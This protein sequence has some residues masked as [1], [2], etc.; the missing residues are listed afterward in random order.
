MTD[1]WFD[2]D[3]C[4]IATSGYDTYERIFKGWAV[5]YK[6]ERRH[7]HFPTLKGYVKRHHEDVYMTARAYAR[8]MGEI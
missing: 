8:V 7:G 6:A 5:E 1:N 4:I 2:I 3:Q